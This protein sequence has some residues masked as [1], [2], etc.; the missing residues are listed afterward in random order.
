VLI[1]DDQVDARLVLRAMLEAS[2]RFEVVAECE[3]GAEAVAEA[4]RLQPDLVVLDLEMPG[5]TG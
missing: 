2:G 3:D 5:S 4:A 1:V